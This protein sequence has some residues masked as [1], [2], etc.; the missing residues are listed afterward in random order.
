VSGTQSALVPTLGTK[1]WIDEIKMSLGLP[2]T[3]LWEPWF[4]QNINAGDTEEL[5]GL[6][7]ITVR[8]AGYDGC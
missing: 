7:F 2:N 5:P 8:S 1:R 6:T 3:R 4:Y